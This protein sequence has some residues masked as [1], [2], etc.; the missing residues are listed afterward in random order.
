MMTMTIGKISIGFNQWIQLVRVVSLDRLFYTKS[1]LG[2]QLSIPINKR[3]KDM[4]IYEHSEIVNNRDINMCK[5][6]G[7]Y[8]RKAINYLAKKCEA[9]GVDYYRIGNVAMIITKDATFIECCECGERIMVYSRYLPE[10]GYVYVYNS[11]R[12][13]TVEYNMGD[14]VVGLDAHHK[15]IAICGDCRYQY[16]LNSCELCGTFSQNPTS[17]RSRNVDAAIFDSY[18]DCD[19]RT[20]FIILNPEEDNTAEEFNWLCPTCV[21]TYANEFD[22]YGTE[23]RQ[24]DRCRSIHPA[25]DLSYSDDE[26]DENRYCE[27]CCSE[28]NDE[29]HNHNCQE[30]EGEWEDL[31]CDFINEYHGANHNSVDCGDKEMLGA[32]YEILCF[33][34]D[35]LEDFD[36]RWSFCNKIS[37][38]GAITRDSSVDLE[39]V[40]APLELE[41]LRHSILQIAKICREK[42]VQAWDENKCGLHFHINRQGMTDFP[43]IYH[44]L[45]DNS[46]NLFKLSGRK[47]GR[48]G[49]C[50]FYFPHKDDELLE[51]CT[52]YDRYLAI[53]LQN[54]RTVEFRF[55]RNTTNETR[56]N[57]YFDFLKALLAHQKELDNYTWEMLIKDTK[58]KFLMDM[59]NVPYEESELIAEAA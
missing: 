40:T 34:N 9:F 55:F 33:N 17:R 23:Y 5:L 16:G 26:W 1:Y 22:E 51:S 46:D 38:Y 10:D 45:K 21:A 43:K 39:I 20:A 14:I 32:E 27:R 35:N 29:Y 48:T 52:N 50:Q 37:K 18:Y 42:Y 58:N 13:N 47:K 12:G 11:G 41:N 8:T 44:F 57:G 30:N 2:I 7:R 4:R 19:E 24:C 59:F 25:D 54:R 28:V 6:Q 36:D 56:L 49:Y 53:N 3:N 15:L 31:N